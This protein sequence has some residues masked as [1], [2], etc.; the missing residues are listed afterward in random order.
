MTGSN[1]AK[2][3]SAMTY[4]KSLTSIVVSVGGLALFL[5]MAST[6]L[7]SQ[8]IGSA[9]RSYFYTVNPSENLFSP[10]TASESS[11]ANLDSTNSISGVS[12]G[13]G[14]SVKGTETSENKP[15]ETKIADENP[16]LEQE[17]RKLNSSVSSDLSSDTTLDKSING[18]V[19]PAVN[20]N[21]GN[22]DTLSPVENFSGDSDRQESNKT[23]AS[24]GEPGKVIMIPPCFCYGFV[25]AFCFISHSFGSYFLVIIW[26]YDV[27]SCLPDILIM[28][29][30]NCSPFFNCVEGVT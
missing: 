24:L 17:V 9:I 22:I 30:R 12:S 6:L 23:V 19:S 29:V 10:I 1:P 7:V 14:D 3:A 28:V 25:F 27:C 2:E 8:P 15:L 20:K 5:I 16:E 18:S 11:S 13:Q 4:P 26:I 21:Y